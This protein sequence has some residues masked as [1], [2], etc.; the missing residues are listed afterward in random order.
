[1]DV[2]MPKVDGL[3]AIRS[4]RAEEA[5]SKIPIVA[6]TA[7]SMQGDRERCLD[8]GANEYINK[9]VNLVQLAD[10]VERLLGELVERKQ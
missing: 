6:V 8:A 2:Q 4:I 1:M 3:Q 7:L 5:T 9:P 10:L